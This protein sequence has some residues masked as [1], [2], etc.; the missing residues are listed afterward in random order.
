MLHEYELT[1]GLINN[2]DRIMTRSSA[3]NKNNPAS[4]ARTV[5]LGIHAPVTGGETARVFGSPLYPTAN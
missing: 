3:T 5:S 1:Y 4:I 2:L